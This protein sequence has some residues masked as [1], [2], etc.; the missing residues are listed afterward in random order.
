MSEAEGRMFP[1]YVASC[2]NQ[3]FPK[4]EYICIVFGRTHH[5]SHRLAKS[6]VASTFLETAYAPNPSPSFYQEIEATGLIASRSVK[7]VESLPTGSWVGP[8]IFLMSPTIAVTFQK[9]LFNLTY[10]SN[11]SPDRIRRQCCWKN[12]SD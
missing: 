3:I 1:I 5:I 10:F 7:D 6:P 11:I 4:Q 8:S 9:Y 2:D 12:R